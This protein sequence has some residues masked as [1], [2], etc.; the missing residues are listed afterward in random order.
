MSLPND[1][2]R[3]SFLKASTA[4]AALTALGAPVVARAVRSP[5]ET[6]NIGCIGTGGRCR[7]LMKSLVQVPNVRIAAVCD[8]YDA[9]LNE[10]RKLADPKAVATKIYKEILDNK[11]ID[12]VLIAAPDHWHV[13][14][15]VDALAADKDVYVEKPLTHRPEEG[16]AILEAQAKSKRIV[17]VGMQQRSMPHIEKARELIRAGRIGKVYKVH[18]TWNRNQDRVQKKPQNIDPKA[19]D[20]KAFLGD[21][22]DQPFD[23][24]RYR[25]LAL[26]LGFRRRRLHRPGR[27][28]DRRGPLAARPRPPADGRG[29]GRQLQQQGRLADAGHGRNPL[30]LSE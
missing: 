6:L 27:S 9:H 20:W 14:M 11:D 4:A 8:I 2:S 12:A 15:A 22:P 30:D 19:L 23:E 26:V 25:Q 13:P 17:Q 1:V 18:L 10:G 5:N 16:K 28:L 21:A 29:D 3:R 24:Y 7:T